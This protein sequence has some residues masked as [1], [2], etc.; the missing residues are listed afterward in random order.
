VVDGPRL[1]TA[2][3][4]SATSGTIATAIGGGAAIAVRAL[5]GGTDGAYALIALAA[6][7]P[8]LLAAALA[9][10]F[11]RSALGPDEAE[12]AARETA[13]A[14][15][16]GLVAG[17]RHLHARRPALYALSATAVHRLCYGLWTVCTVLLYRNYFHDDGVFRA[18]LSGL[19]QIV[20]G[21]AIGGGL[22]ALLT[23]AAARRFGYARWPA[24]MLLASGAVQLALV[25]P[26]RLPLLL[27]GALLLGLA[28]QSFKICV[29]TLVQVSVDDE[30][31]GRVF[32]IYDMLFNLSLVIAAVLTAVVLPDDGH[33]PAA[34]LA[35]GAAYAL[36]AIGYLRLAGAALRPA[37]T[38]STDSA[39]S[40]RFRR[41]HQLS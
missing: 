8:Y 3:A 14:V 15:L 10:P 20:A 27:A 36:C 35:V 31:R 37:A 24:L 2:N 1:V 28:G 29:D 9:R 18:G 32:T 11:E 5:S 22:A 12:R 25:L 41:D 34:V 33:A 6:A 21:L 7:L 38:I 26:Y 30:F 39:K 13:A 19:G 16:H 17:A 23:P 40:G 4:F